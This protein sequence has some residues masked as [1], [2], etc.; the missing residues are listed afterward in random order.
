MSQ[1]QPSNPNAFPIDQL[2]PDVAKISLHQLNKVISDLEGRILTV[3][4]ASISDKRQCEASKSIV[5]Q[6]IWRN[7]DIVREWYYRQTETGG[8]SFP[9]SEAVAVDR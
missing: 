8:S 3:L 4:D 7:F 9:F 6:M 5:R 1:E 2:G